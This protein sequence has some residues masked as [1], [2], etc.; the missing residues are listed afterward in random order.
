MA[1]S[2]LTAWIYCVTEIPAAAL[3]R[4]FKLL[5]LIYDQDG[6]MD[7]VYVNERGRWYLAQNQ[8]RLMVGSELNM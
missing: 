5:S 1:L 7:L 4:L 3:K 2:I 6:R 8:I